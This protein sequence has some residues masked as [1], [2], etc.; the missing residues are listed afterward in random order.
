MSTC[1][2][3]SRLAAAYFGDKIKGK[4]IQFYVAFSLLLSLINYLGSFSYNYTTV[5]VYAAC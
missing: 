3:F 5:L 1:E 4:F 2:F